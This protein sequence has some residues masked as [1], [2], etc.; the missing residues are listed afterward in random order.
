[1]NKSVLILEEKTSTIQ[2]SD[3]LLDSMHLA[4]RVAAWDSL[5]APAHEPGLTA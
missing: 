2:S 4:E 1:M 3:H 5:L